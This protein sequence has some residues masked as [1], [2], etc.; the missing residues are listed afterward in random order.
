MDKSL[1]LNLDRCVG[2]GACVVACQDQN[3][4]FP[5]EGKPAFR[6]IYQMEESGEGGDVIQYFSSGCR[7]CEDSPCLIGCPTGAI[8]RDETTNAVKIDR[9]RCIGC[10]SCAL[11]CPFGVPRYDNDDK[12][13]KCDMCSERVKAGMKPACVKVCPFEALQ[14][15]DPNAVQ[16]DRERAYLG[17]LLEGTRHAR[18][19]R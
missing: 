17:T 12:M 16:G 11:A 19:T 1:Y 6:R 9:D 3:D 5:E 10:H 13:Y 18:D 2:C 15:E 8:F 7:H 4:I 14:Y